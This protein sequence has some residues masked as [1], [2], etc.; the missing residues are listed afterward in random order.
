METTVGRS[1]TAMEMATDVWL[2]FFEQLLKGSRPRTQ[3]IIQIIATWH[4]SKGG[5]QKWATKSRSAYAK[6][7][8]GGFS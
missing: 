8:L 3:C 2:P 1:V 4:P 5:T 6:Y 7:V